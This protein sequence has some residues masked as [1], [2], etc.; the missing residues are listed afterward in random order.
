VFS[1]SHFSLPYI[2]HIAKSALVVIFDRRVGV[3]FHFFP[4]EELEFS[5][6]PFSKE[7]PVFIGNFMK[8]DLYLSIV[9]TDASFAFSASSV[10]SASVSLG[11]RPHASLRMLARVAGMSCDSSIASIER[12]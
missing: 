1:T 11:P 7:K 5:T 2:T 6:S 12:K 4:V 3:D 9:S 10:A 8:E